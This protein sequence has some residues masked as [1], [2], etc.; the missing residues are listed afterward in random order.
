MIAM[1]NMQLV[2]RFACAWREAIRKMIQRVVAALFAAL[3]V[4]GLVNVRVARADDVVWYKPMPGIVPAGS[5][6]FGLYRGSDFRLTRGTCNDCST[7]KQALWYFRDET[8]AVPA[9]GVPVAQFGRGIDVQEDIRRWYAGAKPEDFQARPPLLWIGATHKTHDVRLTDD[10]R[11][12]FQ[13][14]RSVDFKIV[15]KIKT[16]L[17]YYD[18]SSE[19]FFRRRPLRMRGELKGNTFT[20]RTIWPQDWAIDEKKLL[21]E[22]LLADETLQSM[23]RRHVNARHETYE[24]RLLWERA[25]TLKPAQRDWS[26]RAVIGIMLNGAQGD[27]DE[28]HGGH[29]AIVTG[30]HAT[31]S[32]GGM[33]DW[34]VNNF[35]GL[36]SFSEKGI[37]AS[38]LPLDNYLADLNSGQSWYRPSYML[39]AVL[40]NDRAAYAYQAAIARAY[41]RYYR[42]DFKYHHAAANC[43]GISLDTLRALGWAIPLEGPT[44]TVKAVAAY[45]YKAMV[46]GKLS[47]GRE[48]YDYLSEERTRLYPAA[49]YDAAARDLLR[50]ATG[51]VAGAS[52]SAN[53]K[54]LGTL[55]REDLEALVFVRLPQIPS[56]RA[57]GSFPVASYDEYMQRVPADKSQWKIV[58]VDARPFPPELL[59]ADTPKHAA[60]PH[61][62]P[63]AVWVAGMVVLA[64]ALGGILLTMRFARA[65]RSRVEIKNIV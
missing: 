22:P 34:L 15:P 48:A 57:F 53:G 51:S 46:E 30:R 27:D 18:A 63:P 47:A 41:N 49:A 37:T 29:F 55:L 38:M 65:R 7:I 31:A 45:P 50:I 17:S 8:I 56:S 32:Q 59:D 16:N 4:A 39:V 2:Y 43:A 10:A 11:L 1:T 26:G 13:D 54:A 60:A 24:A 19:A 44:A 52:A 14:G 3:T 58:P 64:A 40:K 21:L 12:L 36:D 6:V 33:A 25:P 42:H 5:T 23:T 62:P 35:Y 9:D 20:A 61:L 28:A